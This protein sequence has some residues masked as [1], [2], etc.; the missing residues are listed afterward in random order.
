MRRNGSTRTTTVIIAFLIGL[1]TTGCIGSAP[2]EPTLPSINFAPKLVIELRDNKLNFKRGPREDPAVSI[3]P[4]SAPGGSVMEVANL[5]GRDHRLQA[6]ST[7]DTG[8]LRPGERTTIVLVN[9]TAE[10]KVVEITDAAD[11][12][13]RATITVTPRAL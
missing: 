5:D 6:G 12:A 4:P 1:L 8:T 7:F 11:P 10:D 9:D 2:R 13:N 3:D